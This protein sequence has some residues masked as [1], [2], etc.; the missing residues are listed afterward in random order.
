MKHIPKTGGILLVLLLAAGILMTG[1][2]SGGGYD[3][4]TAENYSYGEDAYDYDYSYDENG[5]VEDAEGDTS[6][7]SPVLNEVKQQTEQIIYTA[8][9]SMETLDYDNTANAVKADIQSCGG[10]VEASTESNDNHDWYE[11]DDN[12]EANRV[13]NVTARIPAEAFQEFIDQLPEYGEIRSQSVN[14]ENVSRE[15]QDIQVQIAALEKEEKRLLEMM[16]AAS[17]IE[18]MITVEERLTVVQSQLNQYKTSLSSLDTDIRYSTVCLTVEEVH[19]YTVQPE[20][21]DTFGKR[22]KEQLSESL[23]GF[24][25]FLEIALFAA[26]RLAPFL[27][28]LVLVVACILGIVHLSNRRKQKKQ[29]P[30]TQPTEKQG[31]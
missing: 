26:I 5:N 13:L 15:Y 25:H 30:P 6:E 10:F 22:L 9:V 27:I 24:L 31:K 1:C 11:A 3:S 20:E 21:P 8:N 16:D 18:E 12:G 28:T 7:E 29:L 17:T 4:Q 23:S 2:S 19:Q 14:A